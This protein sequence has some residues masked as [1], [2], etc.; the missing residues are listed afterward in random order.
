[1]K[2]WSKTP[3]VWEAEEESSFPPVFFLATVKSSL[4]QS[5]T[6]VQFSQK[7]TVQWTCNCTNYFCIF[8]NKEKKGRYFSP[9]MQFLRSGEQKAIKFPFIDVE[10]TAA[11]RAK[12]SEENPRW[13]LILAI[14][15]YGKTPLIK[16]LGQK[17]SA[18]IFWSRDTAR[19]KGRRGKT[20]WARFKEPGINFRDEEFEHLC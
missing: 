17:C 1:M 19:S 3:E 15:R 12:A 11:E 20:P 9:C 6:V 2:Q 10:D 18:G 4:H 16:D 14:I 7:V 13:H 5:Q 8:K